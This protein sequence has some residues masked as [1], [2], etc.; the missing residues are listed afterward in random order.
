MD[1]VKEEKRE[2]NSDKGGKKIKRKKGRD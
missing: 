2:K 1:H